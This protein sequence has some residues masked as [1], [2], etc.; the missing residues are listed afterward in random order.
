MAGIQA[1]ADFIRE[2]GLPATLKELDVNQSQLKEIADSCSI[3]Q[4]SYKVMTHEEILEIFQEC[5]E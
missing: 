2:I 5:Y 4:G 1:L 3:S